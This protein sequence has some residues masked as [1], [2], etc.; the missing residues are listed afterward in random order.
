MMVF[1]CVRIISRAGD[2]ELQGNCANKLGDIDQGSAPLINPV[3]A[4]ACEIPRPSEILQ[5]MVKEV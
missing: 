3:A 4:G 2:W 5:N 1:R